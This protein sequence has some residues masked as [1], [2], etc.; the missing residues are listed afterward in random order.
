MCIHGV[1][2]QQ[3]QRH[4]NPI[5]SE[6]M[7]IGQIQDVHDEVNTFLDTINNL[8]VF[9]L[10]L[11]EA[12]TDQSSNARF[13]RQKAA[14]TIHLSNQTL[15]IENSAIHLKEQLERYK[16]VIGDTVFMLDNSQSI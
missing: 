9:D 8:E 1:I 2:E 3:R 13:T 12:N 6:D 4:E 11:K 16:E 15:S 10:K 14:T 5:S 7:Q